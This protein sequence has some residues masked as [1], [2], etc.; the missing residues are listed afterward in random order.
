[1]LGF[2]VRFRT[3]FLTALYRLELRP[4]VSVSALAVAL[5]EAVTGCFF[6]G[7]IASQ[8]SGFGRFPRPVS[9]TAAA[10]A[11]FPASGISA[12]AV[13]LFLPCSKRPVQAPEAYPTIDADAARLGSWRNGVPPC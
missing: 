2:I 9:D 6:I 10:P 8:A 4:A 12:A 3:A 5:L 1:M 11:A 7:F 13:T